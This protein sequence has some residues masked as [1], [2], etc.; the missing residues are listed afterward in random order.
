MNLDEV[1]SQLQGEEVPADID[2]NAP[3]PGAFP[4]AFKPGDH[5]F[6]FHLV[7]EGQG[8]GPFSVAEIKGGK[9]LQCN[10][11][12]EALLGGGDTSKVPFCRVTTYKSDKMANSQAG[13]LIRSLELRDAYES[14]L[15]ESGTS[16][17]ALVR[18]LQAASGRAVGFASFG[19]S[20]A[21]K[22]SLTVYETGRTKIA[23]PK[24]PT[25]Y[26]RCPWPRDAQGQYL[27]TVPDPQSGAQKYGR[28]GITRLKIAKPQPAQGVSA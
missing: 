2:F 12:A 24:K 26:K 9:Y 25:D 7:E 8:D 27:D 23:M 17:L 10:F 6:I 15:R 16:D 5:S 18:T 28:L 14:N 1:L 22:E 21:F 20:A 19:W 11:V 13:D 3:E 4:P